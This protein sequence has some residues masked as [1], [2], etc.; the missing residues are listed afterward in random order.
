VVAEVADP[1]VQQGPVGGQVVGLV[2]LDRALPR[3]DRLRQPLAGVLRVDRL[4][5]DQR[6]FLGREPGLV[7]QARRVVHPGVFDLAAHAVVDQ[8]RQGMLGA[9]VAEAHRDR[10]LLAADVAVMPAT[11]DRRRSDRARPLRVGHAARGDPV[12]R[13][14]R[15]RLECL[16]PDRP[17]DAQ[18]CQRLRRGLLLGRRHER[19]GE[20]RHELAV[21]APGRLAAEGADHVRA[22][23]LGVDRLADMGE[24]LPCL[25]QHD[26]GGLRGPQRCE[27][28]GDVGFGMGHAAYC[29]MIATRPPADVGS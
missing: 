23:Q 26:T 28:R 22:P 3:R 9:A 5:D 6:V 1:G 4:E 21:V 24:H 29:Y 27:K 25:A 10:F 2:R 16:G 12:G 14:G 13:F 19:P 8:H 17:E 11:A 7:E 15:R 18:Q 20:L